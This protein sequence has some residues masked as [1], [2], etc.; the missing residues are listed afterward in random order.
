M[1]ISPTSKNFN[2][3]PSRPENPRL[4]NTTQKTAE[5]VT[6]QLIRPIN[7][8]RHSLAQNRTAQISYQDHR[9]ICGGRISPDRNIFGPLT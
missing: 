9:K 3:S 4:G 2:T 7:S 6:P 8:E 5:L 1:F